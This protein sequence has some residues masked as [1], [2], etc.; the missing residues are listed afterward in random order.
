[1]Q[2]IEQGHNRGLIMNFVADTLQA[3]PPAS[4]EAE[5]NFSAAKGFLNKERALL[6]NETVANLC[7]IRGTFLYANGKALKMR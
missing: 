3:I 5:R 1:M 6:S 4:T 7:L 2:Q